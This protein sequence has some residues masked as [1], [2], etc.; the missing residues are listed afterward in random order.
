M[1]GDIT[2][3]YIIAIARSVKLEPTRNSIE[4][5]DTEGDPEG[6]VKVQKLELKNEKHLLLPAYNVTSLIPRFPGSRM[7]S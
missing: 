4:K 5:Q 6:E 1:F 2:P 3:D 7:Q